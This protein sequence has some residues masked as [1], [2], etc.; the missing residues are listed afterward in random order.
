M[1]DLRLTTVLLSLLLF[2]ACGEP[3]ATPEP[4]PATDSAPQT[5]VKPKKVPLGDSGAVESGSPAGQPAAPNLDPAPSDYAPELLAVLA[6]AD[7][8][9]GTVDK[10]VHR[11]AGCALGMNGKREMAIGVAGYAMHFCKPACL[12]RF[13]RAPIKEVMALEIK[14]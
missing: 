7:A 11:C 13:R 9:D 3:Q 14:D 10:T 5:S 12:E 4:D 2:A 6:K 1:T 8:K